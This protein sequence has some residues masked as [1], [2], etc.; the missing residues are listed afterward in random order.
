MTETAVK[1]G[2]TGSS[3]PVMRGILQAMPV[4]MGYIPVGFAY[5]VLAGQAGLTLFS[6]LLMSVI[7]YAGSSQLIAAGLFAVGTPMLSIVFTTFIVNLRHLLMSAAV[8]PALSRWSQW[9]RLLFATELTDETFAIHSMQFDKE[10]PSK[11]HVFAVNITSQLSWVI[12][13]WLGFFAGS[14]LTN[15]EAY[16]LDYALPAMFVA[17]L[18]LQIKHRRMV[19]VALVSGAISVL[20]YLIGAKTWAVILAT[21]ISAT[22]GVWLESRSP[23]QE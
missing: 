2:R 19:Y 9:Q 15:I 1:E 23:K 20:L 11:A 8:A 3:S 21:V 12:G 14:K 22:F 10:V 16:G 17:L 13:S 18:L 6:T 5:G 7:V 4:M